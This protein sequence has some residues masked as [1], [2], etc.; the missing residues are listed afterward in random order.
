MVAVSDS[1]HTATQTATADH[2]TTVGSTITLGTITY[3]P[4]Y[5]SFITEWTS[6]YTGLYGAC[7]ADTH[8]IDWNAGT[9]SFVVRS[10]GST[11]RLEV[12]FSGLIT[13][14][15]IFE[16]VQSLVDAIDWDD[17][18]NYQ[19][20]SVSSVSYAFPGRAGGTD[21][22]TSEPKSTPANE[23][24]TSGVLYGVKGYAMRSL[25]RGNFS[26]TFK[27]KECDIDGTPCIQESNINLTGYATDWNTYEH[28][29]SIL[30]VPD[31]GGDMNM[32]SDVA[33]LQSYTL[34]TSDGAL[35]TGLAFWV[36]VLSLSASEQANRKIK[37]PWA[38][39]KGSETTPET[40]YENRFFYFGAQLHV[41]AS[42][43]ETCESGA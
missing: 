19:D 17:V 21:S 27:L 6:G 30:T 23:G 16:A 22:I 37:V 40:G 1:G 26:K 41:A 39:A 31:P 13:D 8:S 29:G 33:E 7:Y 10:D 32:M 12:S 36:P 38:G 42:D 15:D 4:D 35:G 43:P 25:V 24:S 20:L 3:S 14:D 9:E 18:P 28:D 5:S 34:D 2:I 11:R